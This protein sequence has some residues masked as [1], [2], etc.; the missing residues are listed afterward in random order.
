MG[1]RG[2]SARSTT[3]LFKLQ[4]FSKANGVDLYSSQSRVSNS[5]V[6]FKLCNERSKRSNRT[7]VKTCSI[8]PKVTSITQTRRSL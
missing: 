8:E 6:V 5:V 2:P 7:T 3:V 1:L 4:L